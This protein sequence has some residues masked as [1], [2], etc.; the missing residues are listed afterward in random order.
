MTDVLADTSVAL[1]F[2][3][4]SHG[5]HRSVTAAIGNRSLALAG[6]ALCET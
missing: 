6:H 5:A 3:L 2:V 1:P 4:T